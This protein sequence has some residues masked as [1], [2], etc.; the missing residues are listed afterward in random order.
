MSSFVVTAGAK[1]ASRCRAKD[2]NHCPYHGTVESTGAHHFATRA[3]ADAFIESESSERS[4]VGTLSRRRGSGGGLSR[5]RMADRLALASSPSTDREVLSRLAGDKSP[6][7][8]AAIASRDDAPGDAIQGLAFDSSPYVRR[9]ALSNPLIRV[10]MSMLER[11]EAEDIAAARNPSLGEGEI[12]VLSRSQHASVRCII[13][14]RDDIS[15]S[16]V[17]ALAA[18]PDENVRA[19]I[20][21][22]V[23]TD[24]E[25]RELLTHDEY[26]FVR[27][28]AAGSMG[29]SE[30]ERSR[31]F[32]LAGD[33]YAEVR[34][35]VAGNPSTDQ[36]TIRSLWDYDPAGQGTSVSTRAFIAGNPSAP[37]DLL[38]EA[39]R[40]GDPHVRI[41]L[42]RNEGLGD[43]D[44]NGRVQW[45]LADDRDSNVRFSLTLNESTSTSVL[46]A[47]THD[48]DGY[49]AESAQRGLNRRATG[50]ADGR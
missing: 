38:M 43:A 39:T 47:L 17:D 6:E 24:F 48:S 14:R 32:D 36:G 8:R 19:A 31:L 28:R 33:D 13:A 29:G 44:E 27:A 23:V 50:S 41:A 30:R 7:V 25:H 21:G 16:I 40:D 37:A 12:G 10:N 35:A 42:A 18:D 34:A 46:E 4:V 15:P 5:M 49:V 45:A 3:E 1:S 26:P 20:A 9:M 11:S 2:P 22:N